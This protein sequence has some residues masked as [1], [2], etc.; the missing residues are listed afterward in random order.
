MTEYASLENQQITPRKRIRL[1]H[2]IAKNNTTSATKRESIS[3]N[4]ILVLLAQVRILV[5]QRGEKWLEKVTFFVAFN[6]LNLIYVDCF[7]IGFTSEYRKKYFV[8]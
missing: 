7:S 1:P 5:G 4:F 8:G 3:T 2:C 6:V